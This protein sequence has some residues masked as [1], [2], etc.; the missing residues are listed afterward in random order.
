[1]NRFP[2]CPYPVAS[3]T[4]LL[5]FSAVTS[6]ACAQTAPADPVATGDAQAEPVRVVVTAR[7][8]DEAITDVPMAVSSF[9]ERAIS[10]Y[11]IQ[12][13][14]DFALKTPNLSF[15]YGNGGTA[16]NPGT[17]F[18]DART[19]A[20]R[21]VAGA[22]TT[23][24][25]IDDTPLPG[26]VDVRIVD[27]MQIEVLKGPQGTL[28]GES[29]L[30]G[31]VR[32]ISKAPSLQ[33]NE[34]RYAAEGG[35]TSGEGGF[36]RGAQAVANIVLA[37]GT[38]A[39][40]LVT[41]ADSNS[42]YLSRSYQSDINNP[43]SP[44]VVVGNQ[45]ALRNTAGS[46]TALLRATGDLDVTLRLAYQNQSTYGFPA[47]YAPLP[48]FTPVTVVDHLANVQPV[49]G[50]IWTLPS[51]AIKYHG[52]GWT[53]VSSTSQFERRTHDLEDS[54]EGTAAYWGSTIPQAYAWD[55]THR[56][57][58]LSHETRISFDA[59]DRLSGTVGV[60]YSN[61]HAQFQIGDIYAQLGATAGTPSLIW[62]QL[63]TNVQQDGALFGELYYKLSERLSLTGGLRKY[64]LRQSDDLSFAY[65]S[66]TFASQNHNR[67]SGNS[68]KL[69]MSYQP[70]PGAML[71]ATAAKG[72][73]QGN[74]QFDATGFGC[75]KSLA[76]LGQTPA[77][78][79]R[80]D[81]D[82]VWSYE[83]GGKL[84]LPEPG[85]LLT[86]SVFRIK[87]DHIQQPIFLQSC[88]FYMQGNAGAAV[89]DGAEL[90][91]AGRLS[92]AFKLRA[93]LGYTD[94]R[95][96]QGGNTGQPVGSPV[97][98]VPRLTASLGLV[99][100]TQVRP[101]LRGFGVFDASHVGSSVSANSGADLQLVRAAYK[102]LGA[103]AGLA[104]DRSE[105]SF[106]IKNIGNAR[107][108]LGDIGYIG[109]QRYVAGTTT[110][111]PQVVTMP[112]R[113]FTLQFSSAF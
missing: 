3:L 108:N 68:P 82:S 102:L 6:N 69:A 77:S 107:P 80:I 101:G 61:H 106:G 87:W 49:A 1:V 19:I 97:Y 113:T 103:R 52:A 16:G 64:W 74:A 37:P 42:G 111:V 15:A 105:L 43:A 99:Y 28:F 26:A 5:V 9:S 17:A 67:A 34:L 44:K 31:N 11:H 23:G 93:G 12:S 50:D 13:F 33:R 90:E 71:Y 70:D 72:F 109:Y 10:D 79:T 47:T 55:A 86:G 84:E 81:P 25:Y 78:M 91:L 98:Q 53:L 89:I 24:F 38:A 40:R 21:G 76:L 45:G 112:P 104:W 94:A 20:I 85:L 8:R 46:V 75:D 56:S 110:P 4:A 58:Q 35:V 48:Q 95:I 41:Y 96:T 100:S 65:E 83:A 2:R 7:K 39:L 14:T 73:R 30:G 22:R 54:T 62:R 29:S 59:S 88:G 92:A 63:D 32:L 60:F 66:T 57:R 18:S 36:N 51:L 27:L